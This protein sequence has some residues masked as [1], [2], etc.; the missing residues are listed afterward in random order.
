MG[1]WK[2]VGR[3]S[4]SEAATGLGGPGST[5]RWAAAAP[6]PHWPAQL[7]ARPWA[8]GRQEPALWG[9][10]DSAVAA[11][12]LFPRLHVTSGDFTV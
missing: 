3:D 4:D 11:A 1:A 9:H 7:G 6:G 8:E 12:G 5:L 2:G 10:R